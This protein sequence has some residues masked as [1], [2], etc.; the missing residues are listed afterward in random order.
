MVDIDR[1]TATAATVLLDTSDVW[2]P[3]P[4]LCEHRVCRDGD[5][6]SD[7]VRYVSLRGLAPDVTFSLDRELGELHVTTAAKMRTLTTI[8]LSVAAPRGIEYTR[9]TSLFIN[10]AINGDM[11]DATEFRETARVGAVAEAGLTVGPALIYSA[12]SA[13]TRGELVRGMSNASVDL[14]G[15]MIRIV[16][17]DDVAGGGRLGS[18]TVVGGLHVR[19][20]FSIDPYFVARPTLT[21]SGVVTAPST[22]EVYRGGQLVRRESIA[23]G[24][25]RVED[26]VG[27]SGT[28]A[29]IVVKDSYGLS[30]ATMTTLVAPPVGLLAPGLAAY[31]Y[32]VGFA[33]HEL[34]TASFDYRE[35]TGTALYRRGLSSRLTAGIRA[36]ANPSIINSGALA[37]VQL[38][39]LTIESSGGVSRTSAAVDA[40]AAIDLG[41]QYRS[42]GFSTLMRYVGDRYATL[43]LDLDEDRSRFS[44]ET[45]ASWSPTSNTT[46][47]AT[48]VLERRR[49]AGDRVRGG[50]GLNLRLFGDFALLLSGS[51]AASKQVGRVMEASATIMTTLGPR[52][53]ASVRAG[54]EAGRLAAAATVARATPREG[55]IGYQVDTNY[56]VSPSVSARVSATGSLGRVEAS[57][58]WD[59]VRTRAGISLAGGLVV[60]GGRAFATRPVQGGFALV[61]APGAGGSRVFL[62]NQDA[63]E[64]DDRGD[65]VL[66]ELQAYYANRIRLDAHDLPLDISLVDLEHLIAPPRRGGAIV[67]FVSGSGAIVRG[68]VVVERDGK[69]VDASYGDIILDVPPL[70]GPIGHGGVFELEPVPAGRRTGTV[71]L[72][73]KKCTLVIDVPENR[74]EVDVGEVRCR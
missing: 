1:K 58:M 57:A 63:G 70:R 71:E 69:V 36:E 27:A 21:H 19:R 7:G 52:T 45:S 14:P 64:L 32:S 46:L 10:Y 13:P 9:A 4:L 66:P 73:G 55:G 59:T 12:A 41:M 67:R 5:R 48:G 50:V 15:S 54:A 24:P 17:G 22:V 43:D 44:T 42:V 56:G 47:L 62:E 37:T 74:R 16:A 29:Q 34:A 39:R 72:D 49:D 60:I 53:F 68:R 31:E 2:L 35:L 23:P 26:V 40:A 8:D 25:F 20:D 61:R 51:A 30:R 33:R 38:G 3:A 28:D 6:V 18:S 65:L 11:S